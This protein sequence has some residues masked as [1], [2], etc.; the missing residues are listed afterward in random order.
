MILW[1]NILLI[2]RGLPVDSAEESRRVKVSNT[3]TAGKK[4]KELCSL[5]KPL[6]L[7]H[8]DFKN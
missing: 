2:R 1:L 4:N 5:P 7:A 6:W 8:C 3:A